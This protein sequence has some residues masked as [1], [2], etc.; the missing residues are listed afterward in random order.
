MFFN[1]IKKLKITFKKKME[2]VRIEIRT[3]HPDPTHCHPC[4]DPTL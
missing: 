3:S 1:V 4:R 2:Q